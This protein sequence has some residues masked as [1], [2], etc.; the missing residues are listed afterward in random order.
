MRKLIASVHT[1]VDGYMSGPTGD[2]D[3]PDW[4]YANVPEA[5]ADVQDFMRDV[6][7]ILLGRVTYEGFRQYWPTATGAW[8]DTLN[9]TPKVVLSRG[10]AGLKEVDWG[11]FDTIRLVDHDAEAEVRR[12]KAEPGK[13][14]VLFAS[15]QLVQAF[16][17]SG[18][19]DEYRIVV[20]PTILGSGRPLF[21]GSETRRELRLRSTKP[22]PRGAVSLVYEADGPEPE[23]GHE[24]G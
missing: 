7:L 21:D 20:H 14:I 3:N 19:I 8:A 5:T 10:G 2:E 12:L 13:N 9:R 15:S 11:S 22:Y 6:D 24:A 23:R 1:T 18:L 17:R 4:L 16:T